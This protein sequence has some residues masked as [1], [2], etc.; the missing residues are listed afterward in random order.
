MKMKYLKTGA[1]AALVFTVMFILWALQGGKSHDFEGHCNAC[2]VGLKDPSVL[3]REPNYLCLTCHPNNAKRSH[4]SDFIPG[5]A[6]PAQYPLYKGKM[7]CITCHFPHP[8]YGKDGEGDPAL[9]E[10]V[11]GPYML[12][13]SRVGKIFCFSCH[14]GGFTSDRI[15]SH[16]IAARKAH[17]STMD[18]EQKGL[19]DDNSRECL[20]CHD[21][22]LSK[23]THTQIR[24]LSFKHGRSIGMSHPISVDYEDVY[25]KNPRKYHS[26]QS[27]DA[28]IV[29]I[30]GKIGCETCHNHYS[31]HKKH[32]VMD[33]FKSRLC[34]SCHNL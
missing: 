3:T 6:L 8:K 24:G 31:K 15:D 29:L 12:R 26:P 1:A 11:P 10:A 7:V 18:F 4:P 28:Q 9:V 14:R 21:G 17:T 5:K 25:I 34:L 27:L 20:S 33:N 13:S 23:D 2:H 32:L 19:I 16:A 22:T 30:N